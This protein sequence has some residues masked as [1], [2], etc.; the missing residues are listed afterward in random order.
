MM[1]KLWWEEP[2]ATGH[3]MSSVIKQREMN[4]SVQLMVSPCAV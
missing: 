2:E 3:V 4:A 1:G